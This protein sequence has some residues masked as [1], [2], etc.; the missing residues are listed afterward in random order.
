MSA[1][2]ISKFLRSYTHTHT[3]SHPI[4]DSYLKTL[5]FQAATRKTGPCLFWKT[6]TQ[7]SWRSSASIR[8]G[9]A[10]RGLQTDSRKSTDAWKTLPSVSSLCRHYFIEISFRTL[11]F[12]QLGATPF[13][14]MG[15]SEGGRTAIHVAG[16]GGKNLVPRM[17][18]V[19]TGSRINKLGAMAFAGLNPSSFSDLGRTVARNLS[20]FLRN[21]FYIWLS[22]SRNFP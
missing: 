4:V 19:S 13:T 7:V 14:V 1:V 22:R 8:L 12:Q 9:M 6:S 2:L 3:Y 5:L 21:F 17:I 15:W 20:I 18:L 11:E 10:R 16:Q